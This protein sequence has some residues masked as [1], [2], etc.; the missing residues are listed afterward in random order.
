MNPQSLLAERR[1]CIAELRGER[2]KT[3]RQMLQFR[4]DEIDRELHADGE[5]AWRPS[6]QQEAR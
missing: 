4:I 1:A 5:R 6:D 3:A 2:D